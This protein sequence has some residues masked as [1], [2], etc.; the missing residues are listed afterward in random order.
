MA[1]IDLTKP[2]H[3]LTVDEVIKATQSHK[4]KYL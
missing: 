2:F 1:D 3:K 4:E